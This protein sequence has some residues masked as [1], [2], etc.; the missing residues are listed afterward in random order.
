M[1]IVIV[2]CSVSGNAFINL[3]FYYSHLIN[4]VIL[5]SLKLLRTKIFMDFV[6]IEA[7]TRILSAKNLLTHIY[8]TI[9]EAFIPKNY[10]S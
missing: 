4:K 3:K 5:Y 1:T 8:R 6:T 7:P 2:H 10:F 9:C